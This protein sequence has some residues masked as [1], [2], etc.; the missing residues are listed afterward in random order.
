MQ[1]SRV[2]SQFKL[3]SPNPTTE[4]QSHKSCIYLDGNT[5]LYLHLFSK[6][7]VVTRIYLVQL[8][9]IE[10]SKVKKMDLSKRRSILQK[11][12]SPTADFYKS[13]LTI[14]SFNCHYQPSNLEK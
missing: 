14:P 12:K 11:L 6:F 3:S 10:L 9:Q 13:S 7:Q 1:I 8:L 5:G 4:L 2:S